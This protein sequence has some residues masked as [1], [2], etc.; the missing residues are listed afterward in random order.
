MVE[1]IDTCLWIDFL[2]VKT[3]PE[4]RALAARRINEPSAALC[5]P[6]QFELLR[7]CESKM[8]RGVQQRMNTM[9]LLHTPTDLWRAGLKLGEICYDRRLTINSIDLLIASVCIYYGAILVTFDKQFQS[10]AEFSALKV[11]VIKRP[12]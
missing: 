6:I 9:P 2:R 12:I 1:V 11:D 10:L 8:R 3:V 7:G 5:E 4:V